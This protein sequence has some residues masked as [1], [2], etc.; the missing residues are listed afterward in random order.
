MS[1]HIPPFSPRIYEEAGVGTLYD[2]GRVLGAVDEWSFDGARA[3][4]ISEWSSF[5]PG[6]G[7]TKEA[8]TWLRDQGFS[9]IV[10]NGVGMI[11]D[12]VGDISTSYWECM[13]E[14]GLVDV[15]LDDEGNDI[16]LAR[17]EPVAQ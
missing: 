9:R 10:A 6:N 11:E 12:G 5:Y 7:H 13:F 17:T 16:T 3:I 14:H 8:L 2:D 4:T 1:Q 15:L